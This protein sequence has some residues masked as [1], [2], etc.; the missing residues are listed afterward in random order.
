MIAFLLSPL[1]LRV[2]AGIGIAALLAGLVWSH[3]SKVRKAE[4]AKW[5]PKLTQCETDGKA[6]LDANVALQSEYQ[7][8][9]TRHNVQ[10]KALADEQ[11][12][13]LRERDK[14]L[15]T[16]GLKA[17]EDQAEI[18]R[19]RSLAAA[20]PQPTPEG[21]CATADATLRGLAADLV[22]FDQAGQ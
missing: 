14:A 19:L 17:K 18:D 9:V 1:G 10:F 4:A 8:F 22:R 11:A 13:R 12:R 2:I 6:A 15:A 5:Q 3:D 7:A 21:A 16:L 20:P